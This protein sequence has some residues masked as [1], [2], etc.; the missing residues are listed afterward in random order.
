L[1]FPHNATTVPDHAG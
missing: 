1:S